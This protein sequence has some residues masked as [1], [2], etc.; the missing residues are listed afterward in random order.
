[1]F[2]P[3][4]RL[5]ILMKSLYETTSTC[6][7]QN[8]QTGGAVV[9]TLDIEALTQLGIEEDPALRKGYDGLIWHKIIGIDGKGP[10]LRINDFFFAS[11]LVFAQPW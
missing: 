11:C 3:F 1:M 4:A 8:V 9:P 7:S 10:T 2:D 6:A 5:R